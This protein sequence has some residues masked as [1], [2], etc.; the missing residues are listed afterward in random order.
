MYTV[1]PVHATTLTERPLA[2][3]DRFYSSQAFLH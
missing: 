2:S 1:K 3:C